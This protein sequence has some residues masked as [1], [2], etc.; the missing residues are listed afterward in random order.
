[1]YAWCHAVV[2]VVLFM[3]PEETRDMEMPRLFMR[4]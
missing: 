2:V 3:R 1:M 4:G